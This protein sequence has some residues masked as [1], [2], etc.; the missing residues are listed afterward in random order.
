[1]SAVL[2]A[3]CD[4]A[5]LFPYTTGY[6]LMLPPLRL[7]ATDSTDPPNPHSI[8]PTSN[9]RRPLCDLYSAVLSR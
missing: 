8:L 3:L 9:G 7:T 2:C 4:S 5:V 1:M 6:C